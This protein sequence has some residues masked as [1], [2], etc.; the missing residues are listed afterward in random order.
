MSHPWIIWCSH[1][2][3][4]SVLYTLLACQSKLPDADGEPFDG[5]GQFRHVVNHPCQNQLLTEICQKRWMIR[6]IYSQLPEPFNLA[7][8]KISTETGYR[9]IYLTRD[10]VARAVSHHVAETLDTWL[11]SDRLITKKLFSHATIPPLDVSRWVSHSKRER[12]QWRAIRPFLG[13]H[14][15]YVSF[16]HMFTG[17]LTKRRIM[18]A[19]LAAFINLSIQNTAKTDDLLMNGGQNTRQIWSRVPNIA[20]LR[21]AFTEN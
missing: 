2:T 9:H 10:P 15:M 3:G 7:L 5:A 1:R 11:A 13:E 16:E 20:D 19:K 8:A 4:S 12:V 6:H 18:L 21:A 14:L 17:S